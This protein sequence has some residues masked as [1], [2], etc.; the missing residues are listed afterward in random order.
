MDP[1][2]TAVEELL[3]IA[4]AVPGLEVEFDP[5]DAERAGAFEEDALTYEDASQATIDRIAGAV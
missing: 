2:E 1:N 4:D 3:G 5:E